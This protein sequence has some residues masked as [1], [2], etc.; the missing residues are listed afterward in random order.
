MPVQGGLTSLQVDLEQDD[1]HQQE[2]A[3]PAVPVAPQ[4]YCLG[5]RIERAQ[6]LIAQ[7]RMNLAQVAK[8]VGCRHHSSFTAAFR[9]ATGPPPG[10]YAQAA[11]HTP[12]VPH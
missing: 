9:A 3:Q 11:G 6:A 2:Q 8:A 1:G 10:R 7:G 4:A 5:L 12:A